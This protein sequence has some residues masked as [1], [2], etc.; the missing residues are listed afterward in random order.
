[1]W[2]NFHQM[3]LPNIGKHIDLSAIRQVVE[4]LQIQ[5]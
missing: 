5:K 1:M 4:K 2:V 3:D